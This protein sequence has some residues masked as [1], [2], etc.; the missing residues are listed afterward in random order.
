MPEA[1]YLYSVRECS[2]SGRHTVALHRSPGI[3]RLP[4]LTRGL[5]SAELDAP[6]GRR[7]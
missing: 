1:V 5:E 4:E 3:R 6:G 7:P 2:A